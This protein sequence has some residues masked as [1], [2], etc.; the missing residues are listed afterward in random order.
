MG[1]EPVTLADDFQA[2]EGELATQFGASAT[3]TIPGA[4]YDESEG[5][6]SESATT[7]SVTVIGPYTQQRRYVEQ[8]TATA[9]TATFYLAALGLAATPTSGSRITMGS[10]TWTVVAVDVHT[11]QDA[12]TGY[13]LDVGEVVDG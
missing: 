1:V 2:L 11:I 13:R 4:V 6:T 5:I 8:G 12:T 9:V 3:L 10:R 7:Y